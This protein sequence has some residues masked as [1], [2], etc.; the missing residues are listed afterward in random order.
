MRCYKSIAFPATCTAVAD[1]L[2]SAGLAFIAEIRLVTSFL[3][4]RHTENISEF[5]VDRLALEAQS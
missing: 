4:N 1:D 5:E 2:H 3:G